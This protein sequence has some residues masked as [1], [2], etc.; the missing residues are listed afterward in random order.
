MQLQRY[1]HTGRLTTVTVRITNKNTI[2]TGSKRKLADS[3]AKKW[4]GISFSKTVYN[5]NGIFIKSYD[6]EGHGGYIAVTD[7]PI[8]S[9]GYKE[10]G[11]DSYNPNY[12]VPDF[13]A[14]C[15]EEDCAWAALLL[16]SGEKV[17][18]AIHKAISDDLAPENRE[19]YTLEALLESAQATADRYQQPY[20][21]NDLP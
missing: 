8:Q 10:I 9:E 17:R 3:I 21:E 16:M 4:G 18:T 15:F 6:C 19:R 5:Q 14:Y 12:S 13:Y 11:T 1:N 7:K 2:D 20:I